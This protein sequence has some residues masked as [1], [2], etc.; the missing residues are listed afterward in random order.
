M[1]AK[2]TTRRRFLQQSAE[3]MAAAGL[4][5]VG[6]ETLCGGPVCPQET[7]HSPGAPVFNAPSDP[8]EL[9]LA[10]RQLGYRAAYCPCIALNDKERIR[11]C[12]ALCQARRHAGRG[13]PVVQPAGPNGPPGGQSENGDRRPRPGRGRR[14]PLLRR[15]RRILQSEGVV[16]TAP[17]TSR[18]SSST[19]PWKTPERSSTPSG[20][21]GRNSATR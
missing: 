9:A 14:G 8:E 5:A 21:S 1:H 15:Y 11:D 13:G 17:K 20:R 7:R 2:A 4:L 19:P 16:R 12:P 6:A 10:H 3:A 18:K